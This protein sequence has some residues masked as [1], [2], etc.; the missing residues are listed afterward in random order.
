MSG[1]ITVDVSLQN[2]CEYNRKYINQLIINYCQ[3]EFFELY[4]NRYAEIF[5]EQLYNS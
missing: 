1:I 5:Q 3:R 4:T 2:S